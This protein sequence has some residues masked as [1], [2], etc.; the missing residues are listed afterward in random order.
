MIKR[1]SKD[2]RAFRDTLRSYVSSEILP[3]YKGRFVWVF[4]SIL[5]SFRAKWVRDD[6][7]TSGYLA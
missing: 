7:A 2:V 6:A 3:L 4:R 5:L 1:D